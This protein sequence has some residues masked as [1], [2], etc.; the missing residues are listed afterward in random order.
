MGLCHLRSLYPTSGAVVPCALH[1]RQFRLTVFDCCREVE[2]DFGTA[3][4][5][6]WE[7]HSIGHL[8]YGCHAQCVDIFPADVLQARSGASTS[9][10]AMDQ[11]AV[12]FLHFVIGC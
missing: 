5:V 1:V 2:Y 8:G 9:E 4:Q 12:S 10:D 7:K 11:R 3:T 6:V